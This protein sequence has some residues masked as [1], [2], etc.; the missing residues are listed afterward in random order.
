MT[1]DL[2]LFREFMPPLAPGERILGDKAYVG[3]ARLV[4]PHKKR[5]G[6]AGLTPRQAA[7]NLVHGWYRSTI[8]HCFA[9]LKRSVTIG[10]NM[11]RH[12]AMCTD[13]CRYLSFSVRYRILNSTYRGRYTAQPEFLDRALKIIIHLSA[14][15]TSRHQQRVHRPI[16]GLE[17]API[18]V[19]V[20][21]PAPVIDTG[22]RLRDLRRG[23]TVDV[24]WLALW[25]RGTITYI[26][27]ITGKVNVRFLGHE[28]ST[29]GLLPRHIKI[30]RR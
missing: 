21:P 25:V 1:H 16:L 22:V 29:M 13:F 27:G 15:Y 18:A 17:P 5:R 20:A 26:N 24:Y 9:Y 11:Y 10:H 3:F 7:Y 30:I 8:E 2:R 6:A 28:D 14:V 12:V 19:P 23:M 4:A